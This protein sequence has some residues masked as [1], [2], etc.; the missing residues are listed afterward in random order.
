MAEYKKTLWGWITGIGHGTTKDGPGWRSIVYFK[1]CN[2]RCPWCSSP[3]TNSFGAELALYPD[4]EKYPDRI[5]ASCP[6][7][8][9][10]VSQDGRTATD[11][12]VCKKCRDIACAGL[13]IDGSREKIGS[14][15]SVEEVVTEV[16]GYRR[17]HSDYGVTLSGGEV[18]C[19]WLFALETLKGMKAHGLHTAIETNASFDRLLDAAEWTDLFICDLKHPDPGEHARL[20]GF[21]NETVL[22]N[23]M[24]LASMNHPLWVRI[25]LVP[26]INDG[27][28][29]VRTA[30]LLAPFG[31]GI[32]IEVLGYHRLGV[33]K[34]EALGR[35]YTL[36]RIEPPT[37]AQL[38]RARDVFRSFALDVI[39]T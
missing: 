21:S 4:M 29:L 39:K 22:R 6:R 12:S 37:E 8:A 7:G 34:W 10:A 13:C 24:E 25:P 31:R 28:A 9:I 27:A 32:K 2:F 38:E 14:E 26:G 23:I 5:A 35:E 33:H 36:G 3:E 17:F 30:E 16:A 15:V 18:S 20:T 19:Q 1:G 11:R